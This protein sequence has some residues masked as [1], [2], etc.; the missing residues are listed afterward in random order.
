MHNIL[1][2][3]NLAGKFKIIMEEQLIAEGYNVE[4]LLNEQQFIVEITN[5][6]D[7]TSFTSSGH[8]YDQLWYNVKKDFKKYS[9]NK[10]KK[11]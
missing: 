1:K 7:F 9:L 5:K 10:F 3:K 6:K 8:N 2:K 4:F 11:L